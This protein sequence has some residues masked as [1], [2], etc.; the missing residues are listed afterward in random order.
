MSGSD[1]PLVLVVGDDVGFRALACKALQQDGWRAL[2]IVDGRAAGAE[3]LAC[4]PDLL[5]LDLAAAA[6]DADVCCREFRAHGPLAILFLASSQDALD[7]VMD[8]ERAGDEVMARPVPLRDLVARARV[9]LRMAILARGTA[10]RGRPPR[11]VARGALRVE[12]DRPRAYWDEVEV[13]LT[14]TELAIL[15]MLLGEPDRDFVREELAHA[16][17]DPS[18][19]LDAESVDW[20]LRRIHRKFGAVGGAPVRA[21]AQRGYRLWVD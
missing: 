18:V 3:V 13:H 10:T 16:I 1:R 21:V 14:V 6:L 2:E 12:L 7:L 5:V 11:S 20:H 4:R 8:V 19:V 17:G 9:V 15:R